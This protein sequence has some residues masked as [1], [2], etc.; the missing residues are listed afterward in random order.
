MTAT[1]AKAVATTGAGTRRIGRDERSGGRARAA[2]AANATHGNQSTPSVPTVSAPCAKY[3]AAPAMSGTAGRR[4]VPARRQDDT[5]NI[6]ASATKTISPGT[7]TVAAV[8]STQLWA[9]SAAAPT[10]NSSS[11]FVGR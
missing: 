5:K 4:S 10:G 8:W 7:P 3:A 2:T 6:P 11:L 9:E 1:S